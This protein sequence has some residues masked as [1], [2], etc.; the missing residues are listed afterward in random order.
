METDFFVAE[1]EVLRSIGDR[2]TNVRPIFSK[3]ENWPKNRQ[4]TFLFLRVQTTPTLGGL[5][6]KVGNGED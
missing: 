6:L 2:S 5:P 4:W 3:V 1:S